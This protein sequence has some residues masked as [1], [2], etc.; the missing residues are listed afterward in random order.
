MAIN[1]QSVIPIVRPI[2][3]LRGLIPEETSGRGEIRALQLLLD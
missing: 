2:E 1:L 3:M